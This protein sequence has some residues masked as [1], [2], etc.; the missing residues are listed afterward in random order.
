MEDARGRTVTARTHPRLLGHAA[1]CDEDGEPL[2]DGEPWSSE[3]PRRLVEAIAGP[4][5]DRL[6]DD[7]PDRFDILPLLVATDGAIAA[8]GYERTPAATETR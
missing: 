2:V 1:T 7:G 3:G 4:A 5:H 6:R 8:F